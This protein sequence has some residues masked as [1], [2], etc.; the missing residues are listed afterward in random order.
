MIEDHGSSN[1]VDWM[2]DFCS[3]L[4][5]NADYL[6]NIRNLVQKRKEF[7]SIDEKMADIK[8]RAG[9][10]L[11]K[12]ISDAGSVKIVTAIDKSSEDCSCGRKKC[13]KCNSDVYQELRSLVKYIKAFAADRK[14]VGPLGILTHLREH[15]KIGFQRLEGLIDSGK[16]KVLIQKIIGDKATPNEVEYISSRSD[17]SEES[18]IDDVAEYMNR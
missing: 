4:E 18:A 8:A 7:K 10:G 9:F 15:P 16:L 5:K 3:N 14:D 11:I 2:N 17:S 1:K 6:D 12:D 13:N